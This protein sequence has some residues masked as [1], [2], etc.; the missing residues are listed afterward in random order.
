MLSTSPRG[1]KGLAMYIENPQPSYKPGDTIR[2][3]LFRQVPVLVGAEDVKV[4][5]K[6]TGSV[7]AKLT[8]WSDHT[9]ES[10][11]SYTSCVHLFTGTDT[12]QTLHHGPLH[13]P[14][15]VSGLANDEL[16]PQGYEEDIGQSWPFCVTIPSYTSAS[17]VRG[18]TNSPAPQH[19][20]LPMEEDGHVAMHPLPSSLGF[21]HLECGPGEFLSGGVSYFLEAHLSSVHANRCPWVEVRINIQNHQMATRYSTNTKP[22]ISES[23]VIYGK[24]F[25]S[26]GNEVRFK[27]ETPSTYIVDQRGPLN[28]V[29]HAMW[30]S[31]PNMAKAKPPRKEPIIRVKT[32]IIN[33]VEIIA[34]G[35]L[36]SEWSFT[37]CSHHKIYL[38]RSCFIP[39]SWLHL[40]SS[41]LCQ[42]YIRFNLLLPDLGPLPLD[43]P[44]AHPVPSALSIFLLTESLAGLCCAPLRANSLAVRR[45]PLLFT[46][47]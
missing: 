38:T 23:A 18:D 21:G 40:K 16:G 39:I 5:I 44:L 32:F 46:F 12:L 13:I 25:Y 4:T 28:F 45:L 43:R 36:R 3:R 19:S 35:V 17:W 29:I 47:N 42:N 1:R 7:R 24:R 2:G 37:E 34:I 31:P 30:P 10:Q 14:R 9:G 26:K 20:F 15:I 41:C 8:Q 33:L 27:I 11:R 22:H 6:L